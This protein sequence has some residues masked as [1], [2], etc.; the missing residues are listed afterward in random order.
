[1]VEPGCCDSQAP[2]GISDVALV[3][4]G[5]QKKAPRGPEITSA[6]QKA[7]LGGHGLYFM[8]S[9]RNCNRQFKGA[10][11]L[12]TGQL[13]W[14]VKQHLLGITEDFHAWHGRLVP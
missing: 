13:W 14:T 12:G 5:G 7:D 3:E 8:S 6:D 1:M 9:G 2:G 11:A 4:I 10:P